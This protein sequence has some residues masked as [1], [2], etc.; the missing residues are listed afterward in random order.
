MNFVENFVKMNVTTHSNLNTVS[1]Q[2][3]MVNAAGVCY[4]EVIRINCSKGD[5]FGYLT[6][7]NILNEGG[8]I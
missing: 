8:V 1:K 2:S 5:V 7:R 4:D 6:M 3:N